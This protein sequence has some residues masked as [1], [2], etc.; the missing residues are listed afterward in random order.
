MAP[1]LRRHHTLQRASK[2]P[3]IKRIRRPDRIPVL[4]RLARDVDL[5]TLREEDLVAA[6]DNLTGE[7]A[8][9]LWEMAGHQTIPT[10]EE[11]KVVL[12]HAITLAN[13]LGQP[14]QEAPAEARNQEPQNGQR[15]DAVPARNQ[16]APA[17]APEHDLS[18]QLQQV[19]LQHV[20]YT[21]SQLKALAASNAPDQSILA[22][23]DMLVEVATGCQHPE[24]PLY[25]SLRAQ[26]SR[27]QDKISIKDL[28]IDILC[29]KENDQ[30]SQAVRRLLK[31]EKTKRPEKPAKKENVPQSSPQPASNTVAQ[32]LQGCMPGDMPF[33]G[34]QPLHNMYLPYSPYQMYSGYPNFPGQLSFQPSYRDEPRRGGS[35]GD[36]AANA[37]RSKN[38]ACHFCGVEGHFLRECQAFKKLGNNNSK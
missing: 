2:T 18:Q 3:L 23:L 1:V 27:M 10:K 38:A 31:E 33:P 14:I 25:Q 22:T 12:H 9:D 21:L 11:L 6:I 16:P 7:S 20:T 8:Q 19:K 29:S 36:S 37:Q 32:N 4:A 13:E 28:C 30:V 34:Q 17:A 35:N 24:L 26:A 15:Q 5:D